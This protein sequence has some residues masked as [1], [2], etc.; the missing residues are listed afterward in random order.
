[1]RQVFVVQ[2]QTRWDR[3]LKKS[4]PRVDISL[5]EPFGEI[6]VLVDSDIR[7]HQYGKALAQLN[8][9][10]QD[11]CDDDYLVLTGNPMFIGLAVA[12]AADFNEG[13]IN[14]L[15]WSKTEQAYMPM[16]VANIFGDEEGEEQNVG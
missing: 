6:T 7:S 16:K 8:E 10:L 14:F 9:K 4:V 12:V 3:E 11:F 1:M 13:R 2:E 5:A 15:Q